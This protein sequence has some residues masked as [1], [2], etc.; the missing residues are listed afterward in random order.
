MSHADHPP[1][2]PDIRDEAGE[3]PRWV[4]IFGIALFALIVAYV[5]WAHRHHETAQIEGGEAE[6]AAQAH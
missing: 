1:Q 2:L 3:T 4:P 5:W 6:A